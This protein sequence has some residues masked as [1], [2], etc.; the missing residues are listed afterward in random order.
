[1]Q[2]VADVKLLYIRAG[3]SRALLQCMVKCVKSNEMVTPESKLGQCTAQV[4]D[5]L[6]RTHDPNSILRKGGA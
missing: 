1:M 6:Q 4:T 3:E 2:A 5:Y